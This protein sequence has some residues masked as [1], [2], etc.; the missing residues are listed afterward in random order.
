M[1]G[2]YRPRHPERT[3]LCRV[4]FRHFDRFLTEYESRFEREY[5][6]A[7]RDL[8][9]GD[10]GDARP[11]GAVEP[12]MGRADSLLA[13]QRL[14]GPQPGPGQ[15]EAGG[16][17][18]GEVHVVDR[19]IEHLKLAFVAAKPP[20]PQAAFQGLLWEAEPPSGFFPDPPAEYVS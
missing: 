16:G 3:V 5:G 20:P 6:F 12:G 2:V 9:P 19:I 13:A 17:A 1:A 10:P 18:G 15:D 4:L 8:R 11:Q 7:G 14:L